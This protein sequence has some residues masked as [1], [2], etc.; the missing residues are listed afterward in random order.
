MFRTFS[1]FAIF[2]NSPDLH[3]VDH[4]RVDFRLEFRKVIGFSLVLGEQVIHIYIFAREDGP[5]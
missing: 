4:E 1:K 3:P 2:S 5:G